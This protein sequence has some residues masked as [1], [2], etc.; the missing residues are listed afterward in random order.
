MYDALGKIARLIE[1]KFC[2]KLIAE[3][4]H[5]VLLIL[6]RF[7]MATV[8]LSTP[9]SFGVADDSLFEM[10]VTGDRRRRLPYQ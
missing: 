10:A 9:L 5:S 7:F 4:Y 6:R 3:K 8:S 2:K 1:G